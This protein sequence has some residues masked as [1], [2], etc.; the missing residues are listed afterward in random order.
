M[1]VRIA[2]PSQA[3]SVVKVEE[4]LVGSLVLPTYPYQI[5]SEIE[6]HMPIP[7]THPRARVQVPGCNIGPP[8]PRR[9]KTV[10][11]ASGSKQS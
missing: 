9:H 6:T 4:R 7:R 2:E 10:V 5:E 3:V 11:P 8:A 1:V